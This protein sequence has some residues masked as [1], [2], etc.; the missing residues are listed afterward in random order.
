MRDSAMLPKAHHCGRS[1]FHCSGFT[2]PTL[3]STVAVP[4]VAELVRQAFRRV[5]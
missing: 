1:P 3:H 5:P 2:M 4:A